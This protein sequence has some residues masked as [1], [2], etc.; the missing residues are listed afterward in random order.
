[1]T[2][3][4]KRQHWM[5]VALVT[6]A[7][8]TAS[9]LITYF[10]S[11]VGLH[12]PALAPALGVPSVVAPVASYWAGAMML[13]IHE[14]N[15]ALAHQLRHDPMTGLLRRSAFFEMFEQSSPPPSGAFLMID[16]DE[17]K[18]INDTYGHTVGDRVI[19]TVGQVLRDHFDSCGSAARFGG[20]EF[21]VFCPGESLERVRERAEKLRLDVMQSTIYSQELSLKITLSIGVACWQ[22][23]APVDEALVSADRAMYRA[24]RAGRNQVALSA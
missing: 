13:R 23:G 11:P 20:E 18:R 10:V 9:L 6:G 17:F 19:C 14:L 4:N 3:E 24:K 21:V 12:M 5:F 7:S 15:T 22:R 16:I 1:M 2:V 8:I